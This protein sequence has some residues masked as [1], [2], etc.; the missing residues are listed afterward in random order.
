MKHVLIIEET[1]MFREY[2]RQKL[3]ANDIEVSYGVN[4][5][6]GITKMKNNHPDLIIMDLQLGR[7]GYMEVLKAKKNTLNVVNVPV[8]VTTRVSPTVSLLCRRLFRSWK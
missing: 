1:P 6:D 8:I 2:I 5:L 7:Q 4:A 3:E